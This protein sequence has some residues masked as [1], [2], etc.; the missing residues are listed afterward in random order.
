MDK[1]DDHI[2]TATAPLTNGKPVARRKLPRASDPKAYGRL[3]VS[4]DAS[5]LLPEV[6]GRSLI[7]RRF[8][9]IVSAILVDQGGE[10]RCSESRKQ[11]IRRFAA[12]AV[13]A[14]EMEAKLACGEEIDIS[15]HALLCSSLVRLG[16]KIGINRTAK[17]VVDFYKERLPQLAAQQ[18]QQEMRG[19][20]DE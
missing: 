9:D 20:V 11:L 8:R 10:A 7:A 6:D 16:N 1:Y 17:P 15:E 13:L 14:E 5:L 12:A 18:N 3:R 4:N 2:T 19:A